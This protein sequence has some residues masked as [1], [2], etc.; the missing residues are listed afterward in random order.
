MSKPYNASLPRWTEIHLQIK[1]LSNML[2]NTRV[3]FFMKRRIENRD[4]NQRVLRDVGYETVYF[5]WREWK[6]WW[7]R[8]GDEMMQV[9]WDEAFF[10]VLFI[11]LYTIQLCS[12]IKFIIWEM[13]LSLYTP[14]SLAM[15]YMYLNWNVGV[16]SRL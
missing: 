14:A 16:L 1:F 10:F 5:F 11:Y 15:F 9:E 2:T 13:Y 8:R 4:I 6:R 7:W 12:Y 3:K